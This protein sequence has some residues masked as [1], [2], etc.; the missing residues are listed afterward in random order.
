MK[1]A[2]D[3]LDHDDGM[4]T[5]YCS[6]QKAAIED[7]TIDGCRWEA[8]GDLDVA[9]AVLCD[10]PGLITEL[11]AEGYEVDITDYVEPDGHES[12]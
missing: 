5:V 8:P 9:Y 3:N 11:R 4:V 12:A 1:I 10:R 6:N 2:L 7:Q